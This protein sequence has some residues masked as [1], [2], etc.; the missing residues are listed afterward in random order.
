MQVQDINDCVSGS[1]PLRWSS[2]FDHTEAVVSRCN[3]TRKQLDVTVVPSVRKPSGTTT[4][5]H[6]TVRPFF[7]GCA[8]LLRRRSGGVREVSRRFVQGRLEYS[9]SKRASRLACAP[10]I[11][12]TTF[13]AQS[14]YSRLRSSDQPAGGASLMSFTLAIL[15]A[16]FTSFA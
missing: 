10:R 6:L 3:P 13:L 2:R 16:S 4:G 8:Q 15:S 5:P 1:T 12:S 11:W 14:K 7:M 9:A